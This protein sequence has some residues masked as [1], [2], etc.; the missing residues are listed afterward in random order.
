VDW[1]VDFTSETIEGYIIHDLEVLEDCD[2]VVFDSWL[3]QIKN[4]TIM[5]AGS[6]QE[7]RKAGTDEKHIEGFESAV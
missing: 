5:P 4:A 1:D 3:I 7:M 2:H 6:A